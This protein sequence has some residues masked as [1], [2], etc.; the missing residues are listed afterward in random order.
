MISRVLRPLLVVLT[1]AVL[2]AG[3]APA[4]HADTWAHSDRAK[5]VIGYRFDSAPAPCGMYVETPHPEARSQDITRLRVSHGHDM[6][7]LTAEYRDLQGR[8]PHESTFYVRTPTRLWQLDVTRHETHGRTE[9][10]LF[11]APDYEANPHGCGYNSSATGT[12]PCR[13]LSAEIDT[14]T[15]RVDVIVPRS[16]LHD[17]RWVRV[18]LTT[19]GGSANEIRA[20]RWSP[21]GAPGRGRVGPMTPRVHPDPQKAPPS[22]RSRV[23]NSATS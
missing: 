13:G 1:S 11:D 4:A 10:S 15:D 6:L 9:S 5:D 21:T 22:N 17:P 23:T 14:R 20:D 12:G 3:A 7:R 8:G 2:A 19:Y 18:A 16:C